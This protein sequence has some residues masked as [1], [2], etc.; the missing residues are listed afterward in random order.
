MMMLMTMTEPLNSTGG[1]NGEHGEF[2][3]R[4]LE[5]RA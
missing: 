2:P 1:V 5:H 3:G 4:C